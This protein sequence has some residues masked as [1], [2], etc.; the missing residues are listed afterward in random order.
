M[1]S[2]GNNVFAISELFESLGHETFYKVNFVLQMNYIHLI[3]WQITDSWGSG[4]LNTNII[5][6]VS[7]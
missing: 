5:N 4:M 1:F 3:Q 2:L 7:H 6:S